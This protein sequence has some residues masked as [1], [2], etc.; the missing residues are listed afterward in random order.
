[1]RTHEQDRL[2]VAEAARTI[3]SAVNGGNQA[4]LAQSI[5]EVV[6]RDHRTLQQSFISVMMQVLVG[7]ADTNFDLR[8]EQAVKFAGY[9]REMVDEKFGTTRLPNV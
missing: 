8:N 7:Y 4:A 9:V 2:A 5:L 3:L 6:Q 1:M